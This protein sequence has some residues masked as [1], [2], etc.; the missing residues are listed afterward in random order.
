[1]SKPEALYDEL[2]ILIV[3]TLSLEEI[4]PSEIETDA[5]LFVEGLGLDSIDALELAMMLEERYGVT[6]DDDPDKNREIFASV[7]SM[8]AFVS[9]NRAE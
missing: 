2:K 6:L 3:E 9:E 5:S 8:A 4:T 1:M 7:K